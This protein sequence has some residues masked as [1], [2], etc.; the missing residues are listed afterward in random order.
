MKQLNRHNDI[1]LDILLYSV[2]ARQ[3]KQLEEEL[4]TNLLNQYLEDAKY[5]I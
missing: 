2:L 3:G 1:H 5:D 4:L